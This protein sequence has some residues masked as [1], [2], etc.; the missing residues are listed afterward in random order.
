MVR[1]K[2]VGKVQGQRVGWWKRVRVMVARKG[3]V[4]GQRLRVG[5]RD[6]G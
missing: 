6:K 1:V 4:K 5:K 3:R 2:K